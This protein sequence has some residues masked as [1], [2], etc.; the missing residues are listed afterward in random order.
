MHLFSHLAILIWSKLQDKAREARRKKVAKTEEEKS[1]EV[2][3][4][5][6]HCIQ[7]PLLVKFKT[8]AQ[9]EVQDTF[10]AGRQL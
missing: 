1:D 10:T 2:D 8:L 6:S 4:V 3:L 5:S 7:F 9:R